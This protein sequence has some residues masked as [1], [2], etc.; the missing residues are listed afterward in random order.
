MS[1]CYLKECVCKLSRFS[2]VCRFST[3]WTVARQAPLSMGFS[4]Q[5]YCNGLPSPPPGELPDPRVKP[6][7][8]VSLALQVDSLS[9]SHRWKALGIWVKFWVLALV[10]TFYI[11]SSFE[12]HNDPPG[13]YPAFWALLILHY[14]I[15]IWLPWKGRQVG[16]T[17]LKPR[18]HGKW[19]RQEAHQ[20]LTLWRRTPWA[21]QPQLHTGGHS[22][23]GAKMGMIDGKCAR[24]DAKINCKT[25]T[26]KMRSWNSSKR[27][28]THR[29]G[30]GRHRTGKLVSQIHF[31]ERSSQGTFMSF[32]K[33]LMFI[34]W[35]Y[36]QSRNKDNRRRERKY[37][38]QG[39]KAGVRWTGIHI[40][41]LLMS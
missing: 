5:E 2:H 37:G 16:Q 23:A 20:A 28:S 33:G 18:S 9:L 24:A 35:S 3:L 1:S 34:R 13:F 39:K 17:C 19:W 36:L 4:R 11:V 40:Y 10:A 22:N 14:D 15:P 38:H 31:W 25:F 6:A 29:E 32:F 8:P 21:A 12:C 30:R 26:F 27:E 41:T 7:S